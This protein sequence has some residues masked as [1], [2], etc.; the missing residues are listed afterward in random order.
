M[1]ELSLVELD[2]VVGGYSY[3]GGYSMGESSFDIVDGNLSGVAS[4][5]DAQALDGVARSM[6]VDWRVEGTV[7]NG[8]WSVKGTV[9]GKS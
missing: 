8:G 2:L 6:A 7:G 1:R 3:S 5:N 4:Q 9:S